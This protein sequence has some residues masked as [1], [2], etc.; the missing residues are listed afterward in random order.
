VLAGGSLILPSW[1]EPATH[2]IQNEAEST[3]AAKVT[4]EAVVEKLGFAAHV[5]KNTEGYFSILGGYD[6]YQRLL[7]TDFGKVI[8]K[9][10]ADQ[11]EDLAELEEEEEFQ[12]FKAVVGEEIFA[13]FGDNAGNQALN[14]QAINNSS[15]FHQMKMMVKMAAL[16]MDDD[17]DPSEMQGIA[18]SMFS[19]ILGDPVAGV[20]IFE[21]SEMPPVT[22]GFK[23]SDEDMRNQISEMMIGA[24]LSLFDLDDE[25]PF[26]EIEV[27]KDGVALSGMTIN[28]KKLAAL[29]D[30][31]TKQEMTEVFGSRAMVDRV[32]AAVATKNLN[33]AIGVKD[34]YIIVY[35]GGSLD[36]LKFPAKPEDSLLANEGMDFLTDYAAKDIRMLMFGEEEAMKT[37]GG[38]NEVLSSMA[39]GLK[40]GLAEAEVFGDTRDI[41][42]LLGHVA[43]VE[44]KIFD[45]FEYGR[46]GAVA[47]IEDGFKIES[48][49]GSNLASIDTE[50]AHNFAGLGDMEDVVFFSNS[51]SNPQF[52]SKLHDMMD[53]LGEATYLMAKRVAEMEFDDGDFRDFREGFKMFDEMAAGDLKNI[54]QALTT[55]WAQATGDEGALIID[56]KGTMPKVPEVPG[57]IIEK[58]I[59]PRIAYVTPVTDREK[60]STAW[61]KIE[62][63]I[64]NILKTVKEMDGPEIPMQE[65]DDN[66]KEGVTYYTT[67]IQ[68]STKDAR[69][70][71]GMSDKH[72]YFSTSQ[73][74]IAEIDKKLVAGGD[75]PAR[76]GSYTH[77][78]F[79]A[80]REM[81]EYWVK[82]LEENADEIFENEYQRD[83]FKENLPLV[84]ELLAAFAHLD[85][86]T[87]HTRME[88]GEARSSVHFNVK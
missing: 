56:T 12:M 69:P 25:A 42:A 36:G 52:T 19:S 49:G 58:G 47:F 44:D 80:A 33:I 57:V 41:Q 10:M 66:T 4:P 81:A 13:A 20:P 14:L 54:W 26:D 28:G 65:F 21:K 30:E 32:L 62:T 29:A 17:A 6:M 86:M 37:I 24:V 59:V 53:S 76:K 71:V 79:S 23:V 9:M 84:K 46:T 72:F 11:G 48:H 63:S 67:A 7:K 3:P 70:V 43:K 31:D 34:S 15:S 82:L 61:K 77:V 68:F 16:S 83:D 78:N 2:L 8:V 45:M 1:G 40:E 85:N 50:T 35:L 22:V 39:K 55:D 74:F 60:M 51:R 38:A 18:M 88:D 5:P 73:N 27:E 87:A 75:I 64:T